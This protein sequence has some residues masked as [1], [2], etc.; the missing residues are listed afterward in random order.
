MNRIVL[1]SVLFI[2]AVASAQPRDADDLAVIVHPE[3]PAKTLAKEQLESIF[4]SVRRTWS[5]G[6]GVI[7]FSYAPENLLR[8]KFDRAAL[9]LKPEQVGRFWIDQ[10]IRGNARPPRQVPDPALLARLV[11][12]L[13]GSIGFVPANMVPKDV[14]IVARVRN[15]VITPP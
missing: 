15:G 3:V 1:L 8:Q 9:G 12:R 10:R 5:D 2:A 6:S 14:R 13:R 11:G 4:T 7:A